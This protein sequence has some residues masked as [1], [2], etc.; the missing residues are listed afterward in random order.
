MRLFTTIEK[1]MCNNNSNTAVRYLHAAFHKSKRI[2]MKN[3]FLPGLL[4]LMIMGISSCAVVGG[5]FKAGA[6]VGVLAVVIVIVV[7][8]GLIS[9]FRKK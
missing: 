4:L 5:I 7:I 3:Q 9:M 6:F 2:D 1:K 8:L